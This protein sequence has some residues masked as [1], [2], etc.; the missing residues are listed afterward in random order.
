LADRRCF[1]GQHEK[2]RLERIFRVLLM[3]Q[4][5]PAYMENE[6]PMPGHQLGERRIIAIRREALHQL[7][8][9]QRDG[10]PAQTTNVSQQNGCVRGSH[11]ADS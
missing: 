8:I 1:L 3:A 11:D 7:P 2:H 4:H 9:R 10:G 5:L 6:R